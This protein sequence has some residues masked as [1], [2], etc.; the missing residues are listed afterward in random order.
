VNAGACQI[1]ALNYICGHVCSSL[2]AIVHR[3]KILVSIVQESGELWQG[4]MVQQCCGDVDVFGG[5]Q[6]ASVLTASP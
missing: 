4:S 6:P 3:Q 1:Y 5:L 2:L